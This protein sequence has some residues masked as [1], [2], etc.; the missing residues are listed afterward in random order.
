M[1]AGVQLCLCVGVV[2]PAARAQLCVGV[3]VRAT[4]AQPCVGV[5]VRAARLPPATTHDVCVSWTTASMCALAGVGNSPSVVQLIRR[6]TRLAINLPQ[7]QSPSMPILP[8]SHH[9]PP[10]CRADQ[11]GGGGGAAARGCQE[12]GH[13]LRHRCVCGSAGRPSPLGVRRLHAWPAHA[14]P[15]LCM[16]LLRDPVLP[17]SVSAVRQAACLACTPPRRPAGRQ[18]GCRRPALPPR[19]EAGGAGGGWFEVWSCAGHDLAMMSRSWHRLQ[20]KPCACAPLWRRWHPDPRPRAAVAYVHTCGTGALVAC[21]HHLCSTAPLLCCHTCINHPLVSA[22]SG[23][24][25]LPAVRRR[26]RH[27]RRYRRRPSAASQPGR[28]AGSA[29]VRCGCCC[30]RCCGCCCAALNVVWPHNALA[31][32]L[33]L[34]PW[35]LRAALQCGGRLVD[36]APW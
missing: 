28:H 19:A 25:V 7:F 4:R 30:G 8:N 23:Q 15:L 29:E 1:A 14:A 6:L 5:A 27:P 32:A 22:G 3:A 21:R 11:V 10:C 2:V 31:A 26:L 13:A 20:G 24:A 9:A 17:R 12:P 35:P 36:T 33:W 16:C 18:G 34:L